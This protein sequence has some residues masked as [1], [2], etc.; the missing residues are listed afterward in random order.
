MLG[1]YVQYDGKLWRV[2]YD[3]GEYGEGAQ[4]ISAGTLE[5]NNVFLG[6]NDSSI[7]W[8]DE[9]VIAEANK[10]STDN[11]SETKLLSSV[12]KRI[13]SYNQTI[14]NL[15]NRRR[16]HH[17]SRPCTDQVKAHAGQ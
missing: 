12:E 15:N 14:E 5:V 9:E 4:L 8:S 6:I 2:L 3:E 17:L 13:Y 11:P 1:K 10:F 7:N 16:R